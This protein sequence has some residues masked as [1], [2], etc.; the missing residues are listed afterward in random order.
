MNDLQLGIGEIWL[1]PRHQSIVIG[2]RSDPEPDDGI[3]PHD[4]KGAVGD[5]D[6]N[7]V[8]CVGRSQPLEI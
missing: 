7:G 3:V 5:A 1:E 4:A 2:V 8:D 6:A